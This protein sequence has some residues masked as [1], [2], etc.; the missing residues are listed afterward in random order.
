MLSMKYNESGA[1][2][3]SCG[4]GQGHAGY[5]EK[6]NEIYVGRGLNCSKKQSAKS[7]SA[8]LFLCTRLFSS[9]ALVLRDFH[10]L[11]VSSPSPS[12]ESEYFS[13]GS[14]HLQVQ[15]SGIL[16]LR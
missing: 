4:R 15:Y 16:Y 10:R 5:S 1:V 8:Q 2:T 7:H 9:T 12:H 6:A 3:S 11:S 14:Q 13:A